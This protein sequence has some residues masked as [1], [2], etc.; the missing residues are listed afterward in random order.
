MCQVSFVHKPLGGW[1]RGLTRAQR[2]TFQH[3]RST[4][5]I[6]GRIMTRGPS[7]TSHDSTHNLFH[8]LLLL[9]P[10]DD[11]WYNVIIPSNGNT[12]VTFGCILLL[13]NL[14]TAAPLSVMLEAG[15]CLTEQTGGHLRL[16]TFNGDDK[17]DSRVKN[18]EQECEECGILEDYHI[19]CAHGLFLYQCG[20]SVHRPPPVAE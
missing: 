7:Y 8:F 12:F 9:V 6:S 19:P 4:Q 18:T 14:E 5:G 10:V 13:H 1:C 2:E 17:V 3:S 16:R 20:G 15:S 11:L